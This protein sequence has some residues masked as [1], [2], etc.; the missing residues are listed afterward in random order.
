[1]SQ[2]KKAPP[3]DIWSA[4]NAKE[5]GSPGKGVSANVKKLLNLES[6]PQIKKLVDILKVIAQHLLNFGNTVLQGV[7]MKVHPLS[8]FGDVLIFFQIDFQCTKQF[9]IVFP[10][11]FNK[12]PDG[13]IIDFQQFFLVRDFEKKPVNSQFI[14]TAY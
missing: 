7:P 4:G 1:M 8:G 6:Q 3:T 2:S 11:I 9:R 13:V 5:G 12:R 14:I 10:V